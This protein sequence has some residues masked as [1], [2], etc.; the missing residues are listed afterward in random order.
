MSTF[1]KGRREYKQASQRVSTKRNINLTEYISW[2]KAKKDFLIS[3]RRRTTFLLE[4]Q[5][6]SSPKLDM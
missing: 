2:K 3:K 1:V 6:Y 5:Y 4:G